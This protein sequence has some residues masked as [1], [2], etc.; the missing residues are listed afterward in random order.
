[1]PVNILVVENC[2]RF[3]AEAEASGPSAG[4]LPEYDVEGAGM[5]MR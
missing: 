5:V 2:G 3:V 1:M 4:I